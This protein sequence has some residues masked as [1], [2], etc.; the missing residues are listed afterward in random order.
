M[1]AL[2]RVRQFIQAVGAWLQPEHA[3]EIRRHLPKEAANLFQ[4]MPSYDRQHARRVL[5]TLQERGYVDSSLLAAAL[6]H[7]VGKTAVQAGRTR[8]WHRV[9]AV[10]MRAI[11]TDLLGRIGQDQPGSWRHPFFVLKHHAII[12]ADLAAQAGC[13][14]QTV[15]LILHHEDPAAEMED[16]YLAALQDADS[17]S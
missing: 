13:S 12:G 9:V 7:D 3:G 8:L 16:P 5:R 17:V 4:S 6:L 10:L 2:Y 1:S 15:A 14:P 11:S